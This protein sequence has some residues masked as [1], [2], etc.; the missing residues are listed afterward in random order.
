MPFRASLD[1]LADWQWR[2]ARRLRR[3]AQSRLLRGLR[4]ESR[5]DRNGWQTLVLQRVQNILKIAATT[6]YYRDRFDEAGLDP[7]SVRDLRDLQALPPLTKECIRRHREQML[8]P[9]VAVQDR[10]KNA[11][12]GSTGEPLEFWQDNHYW[13][14]AEAIDSF[15]NGWWGLKELERTAVIWGADREFTDESMRERIYRW[16]HRR[17]LQNAFRMTQDDLQRFCM[18]IA[19][20]KPACLIGYAS[21][22]HTLA[23]YAAE[24]GYRDLQF[25]VIRSSA[26]MLQPEQRSRIE[27]VFHSPICNFYGSRE[28][29]NLAAECPEGRQLHLISSWRFVEIT[30]ERGKV[31]PPGAAGLVTVTDLGNHAMPMIRYQ[32]GDIASFSDQACRCGRSTPVIAGLLGR[33]SDILRAGNGQ[34]IHGEFFTHLFYG[35]TAISGFQIRQTAID[36]L[37]V[38]YVS[39]GGPTLPV[40]E[41]VRKRIHEKMGETTQVDFVQCEQIPVGKSGKHRFTIC[42]LGDWPTGSFRDQRS[43]GT[44]R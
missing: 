9:Q 5:L 10:R 29:N 21:A 32:N 1:Q 36:R 18:T 4:E 16:T 39:S 35:Q 6:E 13:N 20:W 3:P 33:S 23:D 25:K 8:N 14:V 37:I 38:N 12:G 27:S 17:K 42:E 2:A 43:P 26:E 15:V 28:I 34:K 30:D 44:D 19:K 7:S 24:N 31:L 41:S 22:L 11:T 40:L